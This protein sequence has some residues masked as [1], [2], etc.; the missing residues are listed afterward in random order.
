MGEQQAK[1]TSLDAIEAFRSSAIIFTTKA[2][3]AVDQASDEVRRTR[4]WL[5]GDRK[6]FW[7]NEM[8]K[9]SR[10][11][12]RA[13]QEMVSARFSEFNE[14]QTMQKAALRKA[15]A[16]V[17]EATEKL[18]HIKVWIRN[19][20]STFDPMVKRLDALRFYLEQDMPK[21]IY[22]LL[23]V[24]RTLESYTEAMGSPS[25]SLPS[26]VAAGEPGGEVSRD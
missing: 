25:D 9:R 20:D 23:E 11:L 8:R 18:R 19:F 1:V 22:Y 16:A 15:Q 13:Q 14:S 24:L 10:A 12:E 21:A 5:D 4:F 6:L 17:D 26:D 2:R 3:R 7:E